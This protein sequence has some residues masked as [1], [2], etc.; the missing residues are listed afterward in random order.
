[1]FGHV[2]EMLTAYHH[3]ELSIDDRRRVETHIAQCATCRKEWESIRDVVRL[4][5]RGLHSHGALQASTPAKSSGAWR[6]AW[7]LVPTCVLLLVVGVYTWR[8]RNLPAWHVESSSGAVTKLPVGRWLDTASSEATVQIENIGQVRVEPNSRI[9][10]LES[11]PDEYRMELRQ[12]TMHAQVWAPP[13]L[14]FVETPSATAI[15][16]G[17]AYDLSV[18]KAGDSVLR[19]TLGFVEL[20]SNG[21]SSVVKAGWMAKTRKN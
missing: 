4:V 5:S 14:F 21:R 8:Q 13:K 20:A 3:G 9:R 10:V 18:D 15:D 17:C 2:I 12:G 11:K 19:V 1:M 7:V 16:L 6:L